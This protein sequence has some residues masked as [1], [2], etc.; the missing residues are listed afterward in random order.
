M[1]EARPP[2]NSRSRARRRGAGLKQLS[3]L[4]LRPVTGEGLGDAAVHDGLALLGALT[5][6]EF[7]GCQ[8]TLTDEVRR[9][10][11]RAG[12]GRWRLTGPHPWRRV[13]RSFDH[14][15]MQLQ[16]HECVILREQQSPLGR[17]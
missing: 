1:W 15:C 13:L 7:R 4:V 8:D 9:S 12:R 10:R 3:S 17:P 2:V 5:R 11:A 16:A 14:G 6:L